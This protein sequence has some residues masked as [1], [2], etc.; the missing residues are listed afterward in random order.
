VVGDTAVVPE[1]NNF[2]RVYEFT[3]PTPADPTTDASFYAWE[4]PAASQPVSKIHPDKLYNDYCL[5]G[6][7]NQLF[8]PNKFTRPSDFG[9][10]ITDVTSQHKSW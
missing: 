5:P 1:W 6:G 8:L 3:V 7:G 10:H 4:G 9:N 2:Q